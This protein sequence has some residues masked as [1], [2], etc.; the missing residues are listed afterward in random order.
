[1]D[2]QDWVGAAAM[3]GLICEVLSVE[4]DRWSPGDGD[5]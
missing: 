5:E 1:M 3:E 4:F 2:W